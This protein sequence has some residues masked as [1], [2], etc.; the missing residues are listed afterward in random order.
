MNFKFIQ[1]HDGF[2][3]KSRKCSVGPF[4]STITV[5]T[6]DTAFSFFSVLKSRILTVTLLKF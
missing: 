4:L 2:S 5:I 3:R 1:I 6:C